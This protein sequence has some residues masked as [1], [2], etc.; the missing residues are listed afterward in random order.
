MDNQQTDFGYKKVT[1]KEKTHLVAEVFDSVANNYDLMNDLMSFG[2]HRIWKKYIIYCSGIK[3][4]QS[5]LDIA[6]GTGDITKLLQQKTGKTGAVFSMDINANMLQQGRDKLINAGIVSGVHYVQG[7]AEELPFSDQSFA[8]ITIAFG[9]RNI[10]DKHKAIQSIFT[11]LQYSGCLII[12]E[13]SK[14][15]LSLLQPLYDI[16]SFDIIPKIGKFVA[17]DETSYQYLIESIRTHPDQETLANMLKKEGFAKVEYQ[18][19]MGGIVAMHKA[20]KL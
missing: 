2:Q 12:L 15:Q 3:A 19:L 4:G 16:Y 14:L 8:C 18:N 11:K 1:A 10:T 13:F 7:N 20:Y 5:V 9:L 17:K 6:S